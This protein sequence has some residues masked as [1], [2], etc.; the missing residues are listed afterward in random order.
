MLHGDVT[1]HADSQTSAFTISKKELQ[2]VVKRMSTST[3]TNVIRE[4]QTTLP[5]IDTIGGPPVV[6]IS[7]LGLGEMVGLTSNQLQLHMV[8]GQVH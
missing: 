3:I 7:D 5:P 4:L 8:H 1:Q 6:A 2:G